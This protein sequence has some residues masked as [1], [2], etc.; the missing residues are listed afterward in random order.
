MNG[1]SGERLATLGEWMEAAAPF[2]EQC[3][4]ETQ[5]DETPAKMATITAWSERADRELANARDLIERLQDELDAYRFAD[6]ALAE[7]HQ[8][9]EWYGDQWEAADMAMASYRTSPVA[10]MHVH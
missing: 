7:A 5:G 3:V 8:A 2:I 6:A 4:D 10:S 9:E 1:Q